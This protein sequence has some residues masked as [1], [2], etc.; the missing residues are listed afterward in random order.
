MGW[1]LKDRMR[2]QVRVGQKRELKS[3]REGNCSGKEIEMWGE[4]WEGK[5]E[6]GGKKEGRRWRWE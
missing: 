6:T 1:W 3:L 2:Q 5:K 4:K